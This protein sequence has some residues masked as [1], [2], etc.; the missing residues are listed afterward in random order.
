M[1][2]EVTCSEV[3]S[4]ICDSLNEDLHSDRC[5]AIRQHMETCQ[6]CS[7]YKKSVETVIHLYKEYNVEMPDEAHDRLMKILNLK[8]L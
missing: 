3:M 4:K 5:K 2:N 7:D 8:T 6:V 1:L